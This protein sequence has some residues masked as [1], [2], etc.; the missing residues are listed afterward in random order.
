[1]A[2]VVEDGTIVTGANS[3]VSGAELTSFATARGVTLVSG[4]EELLI[5]AMDYIE[6]LQYKGVKYTQAQALQWPRADVYV[7]SYY[8]AVTSIPT[9]LKNGLM[10]CAIAIDEGNDPLQDAPRA[11]TKEKI[12][13]IEVEYKAGAAATVI[14]KKV[15]NALWKLLVAGG[16]NMMVGKG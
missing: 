7:D 13:E 16:G 2:I 10:H 3:Y 9:D 1:M 12:G 6:A 8:L 11:T 4:T 15:K 5:K 14:N